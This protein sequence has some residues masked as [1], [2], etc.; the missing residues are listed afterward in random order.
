[1]VRAGNYAAVFHQKLRQ[2]AHPDAACADEMKPLACYAD[3][4]VDIHRFASAR[5][6]RITN[7]HIRLGHKRRQSI[8]L[9][10]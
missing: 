9:G 10:C 4:V 5:C 1:L 6:F 7:F 2:S 3:S 8:T